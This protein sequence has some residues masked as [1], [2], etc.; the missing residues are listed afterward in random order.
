MSDDEREEFEAKVFKMIYG[1]DN[2]IKQDEEPID[3]IDII[4]KNDN[5][6]RFM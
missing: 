4:D 5:L 2:Q 3:K 1:D 6:P